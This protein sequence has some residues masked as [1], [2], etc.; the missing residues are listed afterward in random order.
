M[1][2]FI[3]LRQIVARIARNNI[4]ALAVVVLLLLAFGTIAII[5]KRGVAYESSGCP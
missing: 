3:V 4:R 2:V 1:V 5:R